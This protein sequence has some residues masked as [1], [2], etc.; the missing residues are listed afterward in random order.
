VQR[1]AIRFQK[2]FIKDNI[3]PKLP[4]IIM[5]SISNITKIK[6]FHKNLSYSQKRLKSFKQTLK[7]IEGIQSRTQLKLCSLQNPRNIL[8][9]ST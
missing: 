7:Q 4:Y 8:D 3:L 5:N 6:M 1:L 2:T 9:G